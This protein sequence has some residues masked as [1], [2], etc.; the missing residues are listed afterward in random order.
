MKQNGIV[1]D[2]DGVLFDTERLGE[3]V[4]HEVAAEMGLEELAAALP[5]V[6]GC[7]AADTQRYME[8][9][10]PH[11]DYAA[12]AKQKRIRM[13]ERLDRDGMPLKPGV[14][15]LLTWLRQE[16]WQVALATSTSR[17]STLHQLELSGLTAFFSVIL[18][19]DCVT[20]SKPNP[21]IYLLTCQ[22]MERAPEET[23]AVEDSFHGVRSAHAAGMQ[24]LMVPDLAQPDADIRAMTWQI[25]DSL[26]EVPAMLQKRQKT[27]F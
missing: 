23:I 20:H 4:W 11:V 8:Q 13:M 16:N 17:T 2:M 14:R 5:S 19:G 7:N 9:R 24:V 12:F 10:F 1:F 26:L 15:E 6:R 25:A 22:K 21:E 18:T 27:M 3:A